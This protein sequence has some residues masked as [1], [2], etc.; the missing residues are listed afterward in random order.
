MHL[1]FSELKNLN[2]LI[3][4]WNQKN[5]YKV[6]FDMI[7]CHTGQSFLVNQKYNMAIRN[8]GKSLVGY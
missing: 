3:D 1:G 7:K 4:C 2:E 5:G 8:N 6:E